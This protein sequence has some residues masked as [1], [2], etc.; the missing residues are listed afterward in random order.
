[1][2][3]DDHGWML[4]QLRKAQEAE[5]D[6][7]NWAR[8]AE[9]FIAKRDGQWEPHLVQQ[10]SK[11]PRYTFDQVSPIIEQIAG[12]MERADFDIK[13]SPGRQ[14]QQGNRRDL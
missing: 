13:V 12:P 4:K 3:F 11:K 5:T 8:E 6:S 1:M 2:D 7:R 10:N 14:C 9:L